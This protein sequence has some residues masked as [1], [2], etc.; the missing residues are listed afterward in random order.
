MRKLLLTALSL[1]ILA[2][3]VLG[4]AAPAPE[5]IIET[6]VVEK[7]V[8]QTAVPAAAAPAEPAAVVYDRKETLYTSGTQ[9]GPPSSWNPWN[10][11]GYAM[12][13]IGLVYET[14]YIYDPIADK[15]TPW[16]AEKDMNWVDDTTLRIKLRDGLT[17]SDG[18]KL[19]ADDVKFTYELADP[20]GKTKAGLNF[21][22][23]WTFLASVDKVDDLTVDFKFKE[24]PAYQE[25]GFY[26]WQ[27]PIVPA[28]IWS[29]LDV[30]DVTGGANEKGIGSGPYMFESNDQDRQVLVRNDSWWGIKAF[31][32]TPGPKRI[33]D[34]VNGSNNVALGLVL[35]GGLDLS[36]NFLPGVASLVKGGYGVQ[37][38]YKEAPYMLSANVA[39]L[40]IN[41]QVKPL[42]DVNFRKAMAYAIDLNDI[43]QNDYTG[44]VK[45]ADPT[46][47]LPTW[48]KYVDKDQVAKL[49]WTYDPEKA[50]KILADA[51]YKD[52][53]NDG[54]VEAKDGS[55]IALKV[56]CPSGWTDWMA[57]IQIISKN[58]QAVG[59]NITPEYPDYGPWR[60]AQLKGTFELSLQNESQMSSTP[61][62]YYKWVFQNPIANIATAQYGNYGRYENK[63]AFDLVNQL[64][65][66]KLGDDAKMKEI[67]SKLQAITMTEFPTIPLWY[68][69][70]W[71]QYSNAVW[72]NWPSGDEGSNHFLPGSWR[73][74]W[75]MSG[76]QMLLDLKPAAQD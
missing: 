68:N 12:G 33:V 66:V 71:A 47:L 69:G 67:A 26:L 15:F 7:T 45:A 5:K 2:A 14:L 38:Y 56:T 6:V 11:G 13:T 60:D 31:N 62:S 42:D 43:V 4:C 61:W 9:W 3:M 40:I 59:M 23:L 37:T 65:Q 28:A 36:N 25:V 53:D 17:W 16:L 21:A 52:V 35:Q 72:T 54:F 34:I 48:D 18:S 22:G 63:E 75:N 51:G 74:Y 46:G 73:G 29:K 57:A 49:G 24:N 19:T 55:K 41:E 70:L 58:A 39:A 27:T 64:N 76:I 32:K 8:I 30:K 20:N 10:G 50:K 1:V 44:I